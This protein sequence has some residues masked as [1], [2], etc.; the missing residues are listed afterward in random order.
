[1]S[2]IY[3]LIPQKDNFHDFYFVRFVENVTGKSFHGSIL[4][5]IVFL[6]FSLLIGAFAFLVEALVSVFILNESEIITIIVHASASFFKYSLSAFGSL[7][8][9]FILSGWKERFVSRWGYNKNIVSTIILCIMI[10]PF[11]IALLVLYHNLTK[12]N[13]NVTTDLINDPKINFDKSVSHTKQSVKLEYIDE[14]KESSNNNDLNKYANFS[15]EEFDDF[16][17]ENSFTDVSAVYTSKMIGKGFESISLFPD[18]KNTDWDM[19]LHELEEVSSNSTTQA[20]IMILNALIKRPPFTVIE[21][22]LKRGHQLNGNH[23]GFLVETFNVDELKVLENYGV[24]LSL[25]S[26]DGR[27]AL[28]SSLLHNEGPAVFEY[29]LSKDALVLS[30]DVDVLKEV[31]IL[32]SKL[33]RPTKFAQKLIDRGVIISDEAKHW[34]EHDLKKNNPRYHFLVKSQLDI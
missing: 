6:G 18:A 14:I 3:S 26:S 17:G 9:L 2:K 16:L 27:N 25:T 11:I 12:D 31:L 32:S 7:W 20:D 19:F 22:V 24:D 30:E 10:I 34:I 4:L 28:V 5:A 13:M 29:L 33:G 15:A 23:A 1:M 8:L 21:E